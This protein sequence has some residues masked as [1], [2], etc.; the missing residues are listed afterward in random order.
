MIAFAGGNDPAVN[1]IEPIGAKMPYRSH[2][3]YVFRFI[4]A[5]RAVE[6]DG[7]ILR[8]AA[9]RLVLEAAFSDIAK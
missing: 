7:F 3:G 1:A 5:T 6:N 8:S 9:L 2:A 4:A